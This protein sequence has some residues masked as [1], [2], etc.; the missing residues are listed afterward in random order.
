MFDIYEMGRFTLE[1]NKEM[2]KTY[3]QSGESSTQTVRSNEKKFGKKEVLSSQ[4]VVQFV[5]RVRE[6]ESLLDK[7]TRSRSRTM[8]LAEN[9]AAV[10]Q[11][12]LEHPS[13]R[14]R[15]QE[16]NISRTSLRKI[17]HKDLGMKAY[18]FKII[19][20]LKPH[21]HPMHFRF[22]PW[23]EDRLVE[24]EHFYRKIIF[25]DKAHF[26]IEGYVN[27]QNCRI[28]GSKNPNIIIVKSMHPQ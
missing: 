16:L 4:F 18:K 1:Q 11:S 6:T 27:K 13:T 5:K 21:D 19:Q 15:S 2:L 8:H 9:I 23:T 25:L 14:H 17:L 12:V 28:W 24:N 20:E 3:F 22:A 10:A 7:I 26:H